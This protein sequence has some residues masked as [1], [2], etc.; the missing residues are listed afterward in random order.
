MSVAWP[1]YIP[2]IRARLRKRVAAQDARCCIDGKRDAERVYV[3]ED[4][5]QWVG[6]RV[7]YPLCLRHAV[8]WSEMN[9]GI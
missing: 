9:R 2:L 8:E 1:D 4:I 5:D 3:T 6:K 7:S